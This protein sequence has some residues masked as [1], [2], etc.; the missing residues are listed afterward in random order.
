M[1]LNTYI[2]N[3]EHLKEI[4]K[5]LLIIYLSKRYIYIDLYFT[6]EKYKSMFIYI[7][8]YVFLLIVFSKINMYSYTMITITYMY[9]LYSIKIF[10]NIN[11]QVLNNILY[12]K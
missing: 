1:M 8:N 12:S 9:S 6:W 2:Q 5:G 7:M 3:R 4:I 10:Y 11:Y